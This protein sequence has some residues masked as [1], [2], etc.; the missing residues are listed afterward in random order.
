MTALRIVN[1]DLT[2]H[3]DRDEAAA[4]HFESIT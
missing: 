4:Q 1:S 3:T 2:K